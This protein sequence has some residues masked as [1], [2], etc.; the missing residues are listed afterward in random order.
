M[1]AD[2]I[3]ALLSYAKHFGKIEKAENASMLS[4]NQCS[5]ELEID[6][7]SLSI[8][9]DHVLE[10][11]EDAHRTLVAMLKEASPKD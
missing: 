4:I 10:N 9:F 8:P 11:S 1:N 5:M 2:H 6:G 3:D 7:N